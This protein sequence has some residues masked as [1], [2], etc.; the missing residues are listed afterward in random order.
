MPYKEMAGNC[1][2]LLEGNQQKVSN[3]TSSQPSEGQRSVKTSTHGGD[4]KEKDEPSRRRVRFNVNSVCSLS[5]T[6]FFIRFNT[7]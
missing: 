6:P 4:N 5:Y 2:A 3:F 7:R 1:E